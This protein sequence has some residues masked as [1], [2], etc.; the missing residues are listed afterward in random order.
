MSK[1]SKPDARHTGEA[2]TGLI[3]KGLAAEAV[4]IVREA[5]GEARTAMETAEDS[6]GDMPL[7][8]RIGVHWGSQRRRGKDLIGHDVNVA[9]RVADVAGPTEVVVTRTPITAPSRI[10]NSRA[11]RRSS[12]L[13]RSA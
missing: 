7:W 2:V 1:L 11:L 3:D 8:V 10:V 12:A 13:S 6:D 9:S 4:S 5:M